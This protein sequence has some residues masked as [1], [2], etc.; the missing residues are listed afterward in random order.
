VIRLLAGLSLRAKITAAFVVIV[1]GG[2]SVS[3]LVGSR[4]IAQALLGQASRR[5]RH[6]LEAARMVYVS[7]LDRIRRIVSR[8]AWSDELEAAA[9]DRRVAPLQRMLDEHLR[10]EGGLDF[11]G[12]V[13]RDRSLV[14]HG[15]TAAR[16]TPRSLEPAL[17]AALTGRGV[18]SIEILTAEELALEA[19]ELPGRAQIRVAARAPGGADGAD[20]ADGKV[21]SGMV[22]IAAVPVRSREDVVGAAYGGALLNNGTELVDQIKDL[23]FGRERYDRSEIGAASIFMGDVRIATSL[24]PRPD[25]RGMGTHV[26]G[27]IAET[28]LQRGELWH[29]PA[30]VVNRHYITAY[31]PLRNHSGRIIGMLGVGMQE[32]PFLAV[33]TDM[34]LSFLVVAVIGVLIVLGLTYVITRSMI[35]PLEEMVAGTKRIASGDEDYRVR[36]RSHDEIG[37]LAASFNKMLDALKATKA[38]LQEWAANLE[39]KVRDRTEELVAVQQSMVQSE[40][41][42]SLGRLAAGVAHEVNN[43]LGGILAFSMLALEDCGEDHA[44]R[45]KLELISKQAMRCR[46]IVKGLLDF[47]RKTDIT[48]SPTDVNAVVEKTL[49]L[50]ANQ[51]MFLNIKTVRRF[52][53][54]LPPVLIDAGQ[55]Q[56]VVMNLVLNSVDAMEQTGSLTIETRDE[57]AAGEVILSVADTG[58]GIPA[59]VLP[60]IFEPFFTTKKVGQGTGLG[61]AIVHGIVARA[62]GRIDVATAK[63]GTTFSIHFPSKPAPQAVASG[64]TPS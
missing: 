52:A 10:K 17:R 54:G 26:A 57:R 7:R 19:P 13:G 4:I 45:G 63:T 30:L 56:Q 43:P 40:K 18:E 9:R 5:V 47:S 20:V 42:A 39:A 8:V 27:E 62:G 1:L 51:A 22:L 28:V 50:L 3:T 64:G 38:E 58:K 37:H 6:G 35:L 33:R 53:E 59:E 49:S 16:Q 12:F 25:E 14:A 60:L 48:P 46:D 31:E 2:A 41:L 24:M 44:L 36:V 34:M 15:R 61:L 55:L 23:I 29:G 11:I 32:R 21:R